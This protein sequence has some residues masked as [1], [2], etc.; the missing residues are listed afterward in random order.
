MV[1]NMFL[2]YFHKVI[3]FNTTVECDHIALNLCEIFR[4]VGEMGRDQATNLLEQE[5]DG[6]FLVRIR[7]QRPTYTNESAFALSLKLV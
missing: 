1:I 4:F 6:T 3:L 2:V 5:I 7:P